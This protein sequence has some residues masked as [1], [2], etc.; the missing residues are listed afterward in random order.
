MAVETIRKPGIARSSRLSAERRREWITA[1]LFIAPWLITTSVFMVGLLVYAFYTSLTNRGSPLE[2]EVEF[3]GF[4]NYLAALRNTEFL[5]ALGNVFW[6]FVIVTTLQTIGAILLAVA[7]NAPM[8]GQRL[9]RTMF[10]APSVASSVVLSMIFLWLY[11][12]TGFI[13][14]FLNTNIN[15]LADPRGLFQL[16][17]QPF[18]IDVGSRF[19]RGPSVTWTALIAMNIYSTI[20]SL[21]LMFL[22]ALQDIPGHLYE[23]A[24]IDGASKLRQFFSITLPLLRPTIVLVVVLGTIST[25]Q[26]FD[27]VNIMTQGGPSQTT[28]VP[29]YLIYTKTLGTETRAQAGLAAAMAFI[30]AAIIFIISYLQRRFIESGSERA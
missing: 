21:M 13:N 12:R 30:L 7:L 14:Y 4:G 10:Y 6:Y 1:Y 20:P 24:A 5:I 28:L 27:Q 19:L 2:K 9:F 25:F 22:A 8:K 18:G 3:I 15:W 23:A 26:V 17:L 11:I 29:T 16:L